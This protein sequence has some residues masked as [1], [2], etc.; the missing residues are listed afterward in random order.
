[1]AAR[2][3]AMSV[4]RPVITGSRAARSKCAASAA[5]ASSA[6][7]LPSIQAWPTA[8]PQSARRVGGTGVVFDIGEALI[9]VG[10]TFERAALAARLPRDHVLDLLRQLEI[11]VGDALGGVVLQPH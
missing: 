11:L 4:P 9:L 8:P 6:T 10:R 5:A 3:P 1:M 2:A 7:G